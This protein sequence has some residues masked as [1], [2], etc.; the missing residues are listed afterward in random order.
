MEQFN[1]DMIKSQITDN[2][3]VFV[4]LVATALVTNN[5]DYLL[6]VNDLLNAFINEITDET[7][8]ED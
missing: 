6:Y 1:I 7:I 4:Y 5:R 2:L 3:S 8:E